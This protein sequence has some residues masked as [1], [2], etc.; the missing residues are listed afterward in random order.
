MS[1]DED[2]LPDNVSEHDFGEV[3]FVGPPAGNAVS[4]VH[5]YLLGILPSLPQVER[6]Y[7]CVARIVRSRK[8]T[9]ALCFAPSTESNREVIEALA[10][11]FQSLFDQESHVDITF[12]SEEREAELA[13]VCPPFYART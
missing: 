6:A 3:L 1:S 13:Q 11:V 8:N 12:L 9:L 4:V 7:L 10:P 2:P 5:Q